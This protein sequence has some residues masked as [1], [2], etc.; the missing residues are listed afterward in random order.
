MKHLIRFNESK[1]KTN[2]EIYNDIIDCFQDIIDDDPGF[3]KERDLVFNILGNDIHPMEQELTEDDLNYIELFIWYDFMER[4]SN[5]STSLEILEREMKS[6][7]KYFDF[8]EQCIIAIKRFKS[9]NP[10]FN[11]ELTIEDH[12]NLEKQQRCLKIM[13]FID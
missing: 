10:D 4:L 13:F 9:L 11:H 5:P 8:L 6:S 12:L 2:N 7:K 1:T 3:K